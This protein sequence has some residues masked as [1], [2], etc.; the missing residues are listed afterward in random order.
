MTFAITRHAANVSVDVELSLPVCL[1]PEGVIDLVVF[2]DTSQFKA[3]NQLCQSI[4]T[5]NY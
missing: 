5:L 1:N 3:L 4:I 2:I